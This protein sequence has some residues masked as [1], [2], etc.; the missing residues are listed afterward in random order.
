MALW[1][2][3]YRS[4]RMLHGSTAAGL[5]GLLLTANGYWLFVRF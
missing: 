2:V 5:V 4:L 3:L 1:G